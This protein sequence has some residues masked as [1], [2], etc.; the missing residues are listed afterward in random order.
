M[1]IDHFS[2]FIAIVLAVSLATERL[3]LILRTPFRKLNNEKKEADKDKGRRFSVQFLSLFC[4][5]ATTGFLSSG[6]WNIMD[7]IQISG[8][9][10]P[11][12]LPL[13]LIAIL[14]TGGSSLW[15][16]FLGY[17]KAVRDIRRNDVSKN[18]G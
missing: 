11:V 16:N 4:A 18:A 7:S 6:S 3:V 12:E 13:L 9:S 15:K 5:V 8:G 17:T 10:N 1:S 2:E 14:A